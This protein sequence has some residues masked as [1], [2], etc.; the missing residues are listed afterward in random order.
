MTSNNPY[1]N[2]P[3]EPAQQPQENPYGN[4]YGAYTGANDTALNSPNASLAGGQPAGLG[5]RLLAL[6]LDS[7]IVGSVAGGILFFFLAA[8]DF[9]AYLIALDESITY[10]LPAPVIPTGA[11]TLVSTLTS[12]IWFVS[13]LV[14]ESQAK[15]NLGQLISGL[16]TVDATS[17]QKISV[18]QSFIRNSWIIAVALTGL[19]P[20]IGGLLALGIYIA[21][22]VTISNNPEKRSFTDMKAGSRVIK[23]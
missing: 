5:R 15:G 22:A 2:F 3:E 14:L 6:I 12:L 23:V 16:R 21:I 20:F 10:G 4:A 11:L 7:I 1:G 19:V 13:R 8:D 9:Q 17:G 18:Q